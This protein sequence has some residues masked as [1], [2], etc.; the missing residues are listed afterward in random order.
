MESGEEEH[1]QTFRWIFVGM[2][3]SGKTHCLQWQ[4]WE[5]LRREDDLYVFSATG[6]P[7]EWPMTPPERVRAQWDPEYV[8]GLFRKETPGRKVVVI[9]DMLG[10]MEAKDPVLVQLFTQGRHWNMCVCL[11][12][13]K[14][15][16]FGQAVRCNA[17]RIYV[18]RV[19]G[20][21]EMDALWAEY[22]VARHGKRRDFFEELDE[23]TRDYGVVLIEQTRENS[24]FRRI[25]PPARLELFF[26]QGTPVAPGRERH[27]GPEK[28]RGL[29]RELPRGY[30]FLGTKAAAV[31][32]RRG[33][34]FRRR[35]VGAAK[36]GPG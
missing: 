35:G 12:T 33:P 16:G 13:Q 4:L 26:A 5:E 11:L 1:Q 20:R 10:V 32:A 23:G 17:G 25:Q 29:Q 8:Q 7:Q 6:S 34:R 15:L 18:C 24:E 36:A 27:A 19:S 28:R 30:S 3:G 31:T 14:L 9:D 22:A 21:S 2:T